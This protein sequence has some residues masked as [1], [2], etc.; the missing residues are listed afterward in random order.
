MAA[1]MVAGLAEGG[2]ERNSCVNELRPI[3]FR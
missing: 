2:S 1:R 3:E